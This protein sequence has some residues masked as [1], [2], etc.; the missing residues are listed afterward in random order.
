MSLV[1]PAALTTIF[2]SMVE[3]TRPAV[4]VF[5]IA[6]GAAL[7]LL[8]TPGPAAA[9]RSLT[10][11]Q[12]SDILRS[13]ALMGPNGRRIRKIAC[14]AGRVSTVD[15]RWATINLTNTPACVRRYGGA[16]GDVPL[17]RRPTKRSRRWVKRGMIW[18]NC[19]RGTGG[20]S[21]RVL[22]DLGCLMFV[23]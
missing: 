7:M 11:S 18:D 16:T 4:P 10:A 15:Q 2:R 19:S 22:R 13:Y 21:D 23:P 9:S 3:V 5:L 1:P 12:R 20:A 14:I 6:A 17:L 8:T